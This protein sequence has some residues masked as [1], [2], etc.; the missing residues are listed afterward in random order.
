MKTFSDAAVNLFYRVLTCGNVCRTFV[1]FA[2]LAAT[3]IVCQAK[4]EYNLND[5]VTVTNPVDKSGSET[6]KVYSEAQDAVRPESWVISSGRVDCQGY[7]FE[8]VPD[9]VAVECSETFSAGDTEEDYKTYSSEISIERQVKIQFEFDSSSEGASD[10]NFDAMVQLALL[11]NGA[12]SLPKADAE[13]QLVLDPNFAN[14][15]D[16]FDLL[17]DNY[18]DLFQFVGRKNPGLFLIGRSDPEPIPVP[19]STTLALF[20]LGVAGLL[21]LRKR[22]Y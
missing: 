5:P 21:Y 7:F 15:S 3:T 16:H 6:L 17:S 19:E 20:G 12:E 2:C 13:Y 14:I 1:F 9:D 10:E 8:T 4:S 11:D 18:G 22:M